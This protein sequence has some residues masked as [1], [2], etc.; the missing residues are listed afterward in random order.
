MEVS[1][2]WLEPILDRFAKDMNV[3]VWPKIAAVN[4]D[5][6]RLWLDNDE[7]GGIGG[8]KWNMDFNLSYNSTLFVVN[9]IAQKSIGNVTL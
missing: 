1:P 7:P 3:L 6:L 8:F 2:G 9:V 4:K 5:D